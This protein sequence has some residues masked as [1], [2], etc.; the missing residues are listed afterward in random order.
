M[1][2]AANDKP[3]AHCL[4]CNELFELKRADKKFCTEACKTAF[5][6]DKRNQP[7]P[8]PVYTQDISDGRQAFYEK[9][10]RIIRRNRDIMEYLCEIDY[11]S[12]EKTDMEGYGFNFKYFSSEYNDPE[13]GLY[14]FCYEYGYQIYNGRRVHIIIRAEEILC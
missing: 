3:A 8:E 2:K 10:N 4:Y 11:R 7:P 14:R 1:T 9:I 13:H 6:N 12:I 5:H